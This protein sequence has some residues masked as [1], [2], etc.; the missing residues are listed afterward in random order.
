MRLPSYK[1]IVTVAVG[2][3]WLTMRAAACPLCWFG[4]A[5]AH[6]ANFEAVVMGY[7]PLWAS[8]L[9]GVVLYGKNIWRK[10]RG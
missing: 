4:M 8:A 3:C 7:L 2:L 9:T 1:R 6:I 5:Q 10:L